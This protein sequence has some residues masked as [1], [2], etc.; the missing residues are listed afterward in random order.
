METLRSR[1]ALPLSSA[2]ARSAS[3]GV[4]RATKAYPTGREVRGLVGMVVDSL[5]D[6]LA[7]TC[8]MGAECVSTYTR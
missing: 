1:I 5:C 6:G 2:M 3:D 8:V 7:Q 4:E